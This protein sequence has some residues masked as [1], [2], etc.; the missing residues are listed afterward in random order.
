MLNMSK[1]VQKC[2]ALIRKKLVNIFNGEKNILWTLFQA[3]I[4]KVQL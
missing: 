2:L 3:I 1:N 4:S